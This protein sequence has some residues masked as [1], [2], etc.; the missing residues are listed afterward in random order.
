MAGPNTVSIG[1]QE[2][3][4][5]EATY[6]AGEG[7]GTEIKI[8]T[9]RMNIADLRAVGA[10]GAGA[11]PMLDRVA[12]GT[13]RGSL[14]YAKPQP[15]SEAGI[16][17]GDFEVQNTRVA[18][19]GLA[20]PVRI[21]SAAVSVKAEQVAVTRIKA[22][23]GG[24]A[25][26][27]EYRWDADRALPQ[28][29]RLQI[30]E[31]DATEIERLFQPTT[32]REGGLLAR[33]LRLGAAGATPEWLTGRNA[34]G[35]V[36]MQALTVADARLSVTT[37]RLAWDGASVKVS[38]IQGKIGDAALAGELRVDLSGRAPSYRF[39]GKIEDLAY[40]GGKLDFSGKATASG[41][42]QALLA[43]VKAEGTLRGRGI[44]F[45]PDAEFR[46]V[47]GRFQVSVTPA[48]PKWKL[49]GLEL[50]QGSDSYSGEG[51]TQADGRLVLDL[52]SGGRQVRYP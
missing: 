12:D 21:A 8:A 27:G 51:A 24:V 7:G 31:A 33:T 49:S 47:A 15:A 44:A 43:S 42:G 14:T 2:S 20:D 38:G 37:A 3:A 25:F 30:A 18:I 13:W 34:E 17:S 50:T 22:K 41:S 10:L 19:D 29:F 28:R 52:L 11:I 36:S 5:V 9:R 35:T 1:E 46:R 4:E 45:S 26:G 39:E 32:S 16:W 23:T 40:K 48:G 6:Q